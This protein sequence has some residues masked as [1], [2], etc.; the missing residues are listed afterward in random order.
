[1]TK[2]TTPRGWCCA[3]S[4]PQ[5]YDMGLD[6]EVEC[7][8]LRAV[9][10]AS[11]TKRAL[12]FGTFMQSCCARTFAGKRVRFTALVRSEQVTHWA[13][14]WFRIDAVESGRTLGFDNMSERPITGT[15]DWTRHAV[16]LD[17][18]EAGKGLAYGVLL[19]GPGRVWI[20]GV[21]VEVVTADVPTTNMAS[22]FPMPELP[23][24]LE[25]GA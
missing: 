3:G 5:D 19:S 1:M 16:V 23:T 12:G 2:R 9:G 8:G 14:L 24:N 7:D 18:P 11:R 10:I 17:V 13:G 6:P 21:R 4:R 15:T 25:F 22:A 20:A